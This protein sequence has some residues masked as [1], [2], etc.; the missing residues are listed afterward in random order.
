M[1]LPVSGEINMHAADEICL[2]IADELEE[3]F[4]RASGPGGQNVNKAATAVE[5]RFD[6]RG[7]RALPTTV[8][9]SDVNTPPALRLPSLKK[10][11]LEVSQSIPGGCR[12]PVSCR[13]ETHR[14]PKGP[15][16]IGSSVIGAPL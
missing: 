16:L 3:T 1:Q 8:I 9:V 15:R 11:V 10:G 12:E 5:L 13:R 6:V 2:A 7:S 4:V 14:R